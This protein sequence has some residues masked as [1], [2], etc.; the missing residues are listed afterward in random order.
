MK[1]QYFAKTASPGV[2]SSG[3]SDSFSFNLLCAIVNSRYFM[4][5]FCSFSF[6][7]QSSDRGVG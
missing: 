4:K 7:D 1:T 3:K 2:D 6:A 5:I